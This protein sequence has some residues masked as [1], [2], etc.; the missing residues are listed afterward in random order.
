ME[1]QNLGC[2]I[3]GRSDV[4]LSVDHDHK[5][6]RV[7]GLL[8]SRCN[9]TLGHFDDNAELFRNVVNYL[10]YHDGRH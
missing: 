3:C 9:L 5:T 4:D 6:G 1:G 7:R 2:A 10:N 8:C